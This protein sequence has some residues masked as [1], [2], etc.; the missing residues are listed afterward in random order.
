MKRFHLSWREPPDVTSDSTD[1][2]LI[3]AIAAESVTA[4][5][6]LHRRHAPW[7]RT[8]L[9]RRCADPDAVDDALQDTF[10]AV[11]KA[12]ARFDGGNAAG[13]LWTIALRRLVSALRGRG[14]HRF[15]PHRFGSGPVDGRALDE[16]AVE[17]HAIASAEDV[18][19]LGVEHGDLGAALNR[20]S[21]E[22]RAVIQATVLDGLT[23]KEASRLLGVPEGTIKTRAMRARARLREELA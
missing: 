10:L 17:E 7:L 13:W 5:R 8:R 15:G 9:A 6:L 22:L 20:L 1:A 18:A 19:L 12:A 21:P 3:A 4:L 14:S 16:R 11:W 23:V 2:E